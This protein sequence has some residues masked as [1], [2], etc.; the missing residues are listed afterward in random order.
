MKRIILL[1]TVL[2]VFTAFSGLASASTL[3]MTVDGK[4]VAFAYGTPIIENNRSLMPLRDL[5]IALNV[6]NDD[7][8]IIWNQTEKSVTIKQNSDTIKLTVGETNIYKNGKVFEVLEVPAQQV[9]S[10]S[11]RVFLPARAVATALG[12]K[13]GYDAKTSTVQVT[14][15][16]TVIQKNRRLTQESFKQAADIIAAKYNLTNQITEFTDENG[17]KYHSTRATLTSKKD[18]AHDYE[19]QVLVMDYSES[20]NG[21]G[22]VYYLIWDNKTTIS[23]LSVATVGFDFMSQLYGAE[24]FFTEQ[25]MVDITHIKNF[26]YNNSDSTFMFRQS[27]THAPTFDAGNFNGMLY[28]K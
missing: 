3:K 4:N 7:D 10:Q 15:E 8:H 13:V 23:D 2:T 28:E 5:L 9:K 27:Y 14:S 12:Y 11:D 25:N 20:N 22:Y 24:L 1:I 26:D 6:P 19:N 17:L 18:A 16:A 21:A